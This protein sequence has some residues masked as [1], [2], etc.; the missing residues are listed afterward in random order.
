MSAAHGVQAGP[1]W[2]FGPV[3]TPVTGWENTTLGSHSWVVSQNAS[4]NLC[5]GFSLHSPGAPAA[6][7]LSVGFQTVDVWQKPGQQT[8]YGNTTLTAGVHSFVSLLVP[9]QV[10]DLSAGDLRSFDSTIAQTDVGVT[11]TVSWGKTQCKSS[12]F[13]GTAI[14]VVLTGNTWSVKRRPA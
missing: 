1:I 14:D 10:S 7:Q 8:A 4:V 12:G 11:A 6:P 9:V 3:A 5:V 2:H 13:C